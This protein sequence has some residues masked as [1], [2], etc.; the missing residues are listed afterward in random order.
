MEDT[1]DILII[2][3]GVAGITA[4]AALAPQAS[5]ALLEA[6]DHLCYHASGRSA[7]M[8]LESYGNATV[9]ALNEASAEHHRSADGGVLKDRPMMMTA[10]AEDRADF[11]QE[12]RAFSL[13]PI[14]TA[15]ALTYFP[16]LDPERS[17][18]AAI[19]HDTSDIDTDLLVQNAR[20]HARAAG[21]TIATGMRV[22]DI[23]FDGVWQ[24]TT[25]NGDQWQA[26]TLINA[27]GAWAD[28]VAQMAG[29]APLG[30]V[31]YRRSMARIPLPDGLDPSGWAFVDGVREGWYAKPDAG[32]LIV[33][34]SEADRS[35]PMDAWADDMVI[36]E[37]LA[38]FQDHVTMEISRVQ[39]TWAGLRTFAPDG[40]LV[41]GRDADR[42][43]FIWLAGQGGY[44]FQTAPAAAGLVADIALNRPPALP[45]DI[46]T[47][48][49]PERFSR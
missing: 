14:S 33:S 41:I 8:F 28:T 37:G 7:A 40:S 48:L 44:G 16:L 35:E 18:L 10:A 19:R 25:S 9:R 27:A 15:E 17:P 12:S 47:R 21:A 4:A 32:M 5:V 6:E 34:P 30:L 2:G 45:A 24:I 26:R 20:R 11:E 23:R 3:G 36:A 22:A 38:R 29:V 1:F 43:E 46:V 39:S 42:P 31:P 13:T 49:A